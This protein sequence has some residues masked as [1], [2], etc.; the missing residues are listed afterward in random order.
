MKEHKIKKKVALTTFFFITGF[1]IY[2]LLNLF[3]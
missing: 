3:L 1:V 2:I